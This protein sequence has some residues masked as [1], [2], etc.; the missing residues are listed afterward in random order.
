MAENTTTVEDPK[1]RCSPP[2]VPRT[3]ALATVNEIVVTPA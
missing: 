3:L 1:A 2:S